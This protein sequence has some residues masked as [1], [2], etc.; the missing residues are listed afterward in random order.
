MRILLTNIK[1]CDG[2]GTETLIRDLSLALRRRGHVVICFA[3][4]LGRMEAE[5]RATGTPVGVRRKCD[6]AAGAAHLE[7]I[8][9]EVLEACARPLDRAA[10][11]A[12]LA[13]YLEQN[14]QHGRLYQ[15]EFARR[16]FTPT[17]ADEM[18]ATVRKLEMQIEHLGLAIDELSLQ[19]RALARGQPGWSLMQFW[20]ALQAWCTRTLHASNPGKSR[21]APAT[22]EAEGAARAPA[23][24]R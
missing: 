17:P 18:H 16:I 10:E 24:H 11:D 3:P 23:H 4:T 5:I 19:T 9:L 14:L 13:R 2:S 15:S 20:Q 7:A 21:S 6:V 8:Y 12:A 22:Q 1:L